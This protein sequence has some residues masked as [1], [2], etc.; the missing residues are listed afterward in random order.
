MPANIETT[1]GPAADLP[2]LPSTTMVGRMGDNRRD[3]IE[4]LKIRNKE[5]AANEAA[6]RQEQAQAQQPQ[7]AAAPPRQDQ[8]VL[9]SRRQQQAKYDEWRHGRGRDRARHEPRVL[10]DTDRR[11]ATPSKRQ[12]REPASADRTICIYRRDDDGKDDNGAGAFASANQR[13]AHEPSPRREIHVDRD[14]NVSVRL[15]RQ[16]EDENVELL[17]T[18]IETARHM[19]PEAQ[20]S[21]YGCYLL[22]TSNTG[23][24]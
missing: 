21:Q 23:G 22:P 2:D 19:T 20:R 10:D 7:A 17:R 24:R 5:D 3:Y 16:R 13:P 9:M 15:E 11:R 8:P 12:Q 18:A 6:F 1:M 14:R 4:W